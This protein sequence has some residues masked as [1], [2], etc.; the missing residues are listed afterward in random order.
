VQD[1][2]VLMDSLVKA[3]LASIEGGPAYSKSTRL[4]YASDL[5]VFL[6]YVAKR[7]QRTP[8]I[9]DLD[10]EIVADFLKAEINS[11][12]RKNTLLRRLAAF[13]RFVKF[14]VLSG[15]IPADRISLDTVVTAARLGPP[16]EPC[17]S[18]CLSNSQV[19]NLL[20]VMKKSPRP[21]AQRDQAILMLLLETG[22]SVG[23]LTALDLVDIDLGAN[24]L[25][26]RSDSG[27]AGWFSMGVAGRY[28]EK[29]ILGGRQD[30][31]RRPDDPALFISQMN[32]RVS[33][34]GIWQILNHWGRSARLPFSLSPRLLRNTAAW[35]MAQ[36][37]RPLAEIQVL[38]G[39][40]NPLSTR[41]LMR[42]LDAQCP[43]M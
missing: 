6:A 33:R 23:S 35:R 34:Q 26:V 3:F 24:C 20:E 4:A 5:R 17:H 42:R 8:R 40:S 37:G 11:G 28:V 30:M 13:K 21:R 16:T 1:N 15:A 14:L 41:A 43:E 22:L 36:A 29:Y 12:R 2:V 18:A 31:I 27:M 10:E 39:H 25:R 7:L 38:L 9:E 19:A 32:E